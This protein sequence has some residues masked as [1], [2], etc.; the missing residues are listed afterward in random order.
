MA[1]ACATPGCFL[2]CTAYA[3]PGGRLP[4]MSSPQWPRSGCYFLGRVNRNLLE[5]CSPSRH[6]NSQSSTM[7]KSIWPRGMQPR[8]SLKSHLVEVVI[9]FLATVGHGLQTAF[10][11]L[12]PATTSLLLI[13]GGVGFALGRYRPVRCALDISIHDVRRKRVL[14]G[15][16]VSVADG[17]TIRVRHRPLWACLKPLPSKQIIRKAESSLSIRIAAVDAPEI[18]HGTGKGQPFGNESR[19]FTTKTVKNRRVSLKLLARDQYGRLV[20]TVKFGIWPFKKNLSMEL[21]E[22]GLACIYRQSGAEDGYDGMKDIY[23]R[24][25]KEAKKQKRGIWSL[26]DKLVL[27]SEYKAKN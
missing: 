19:D 7:R 14:H 22:H 11:Q 12:T 21:L 5:G 3:S 24:L 25:E 10:S 18:A 26:G 6:C 1:M 13:A 27:P 4:I 20:A 9:S 15:V 16:V 17:D 23:E 2:L 8:P